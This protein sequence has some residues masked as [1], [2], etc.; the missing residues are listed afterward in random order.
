MAATLRSINLSA[1]VIK[2]MPKI[3]ADFEELRILNLEQNQIF[4]IDETWGRLAQQ[5]I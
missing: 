4:H 5:M 2:K 3:E 1:N